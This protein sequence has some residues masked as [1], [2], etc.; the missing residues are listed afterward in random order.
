[1]KV[2]VNFGETRIVV[3]CKDGWMVRDLIDQ[4]TQRYKK[5][6]EQDG[7]FLV[8]TLHVE[9]VDG[10]ILD[11]DDML[12]DLVEDKDKL[13]AV[14]EKM[15][16]QQRAT[17]S[18]GGSVASGRSSPDHSEPELS[19]L[20]PYL[21]SEIEVTPSALKSTTPL[22]VRSSS[23]P[24]LAPPLDVISLDAEDISRPQSTG[25]G[26]AISV[27]GGAMDKPKV[28]VP[29]SR[30]VELSCLT[31]TV[32]ISGDLG[33]LGIKVISY[34]SSLSGRTLGLNIRAIERHSRSER[35]GI[36]EEDE[37]I[38]QINDTELI[39]KSFAQ[40]QEVFRLAM[41][42]TTIRLEV[43][44]VANKLRYEKSLIGQ[45]FNNTEPT[46]AVPKVKSPFLVH[47][48][49]SSNASTPSPEPPASRTPP[50][51]QTPPQKEEE[52]LSAR[53]TPVQTDHHRATPS[54][55]VSAS[56][57]LKDGSESP[58]P[59]K[60][61]TLA[62]VVNMI[63]KKPGKKMKIDLKKG[64]E[65]LGFTVVTRDSSLH[66]PGPIM[67]KSILPRGAAVKDGR[68]KSGDRILE[69]NGVDITGRTQEE[70]VA[71][72]RSTKLGETVSLVVG[73]QEGFLPRELKGEPSGPLLS[74]DG[75]EQL[76][77]E[78]P[79]NDSGSA[80]LGVSLKG[81][82]SR[83]TGEDLGI[84]IKSIIHGGA[85]HKD[86]RLRVNDQLIAV[87]SESLLGRSN[88]DAMETLRRS[89]STEGNLRG[90][91][92][93]VVLRSSER[94]AAQE[95]P[96]SSQT[97]T[98][99]DSPVHLRPNSNHTNSS[100]PPST[101]TIRTYEAAPA[102]YRPPGGP[103]ELPEEDYDEDDFPPPPSDLD[104]LETNHPHKHQQNRGELEPVSYKPT[105]QQ[106]PPRQK[107]PEY[108]ASKSSKSMD[109]VAD[110]SNMASIQGQRPEPP[111]SNGTVLGPR[112]GLQKSSS[113]ES[114]QTAMEE[115]GK[116]QVPF[117]RPRT[118][119]VRGR[120]C[121]LS[122]RYA[123]DKSYEGPS[124][125]EDDDSEEDSG[126]DTPASSSSRQDLD[127]EK[128]VKKKKTKKKKEKK[129][130]KKDESD[131]PEKKTKKKGFGLLR[132]GR[133][134]KSKAKE[135]GAL[136]EEE[137]DKSEPEMFLSKSER[138]SPALDRAIFPDV[139]DDDLDPNYARI[140]NFREPPSSG[141][142]PYPPGTPTHNYS[143]PAVPAPNREL[144]NEDALEGLYAKVNKQRTGPPKTDSNED[145]LQQIRNQLQQVRPAP[146]YDDLSARRRPEYDPSRIRGPDPRMAP[147]YSD[148]DR[149]YTSVPRR[150]PVED[151]TNQN[152]ANQ[153]DPVHY[154]NPIYETQ[155]N[156][157]PRFPRLP[158]PR[159][160]EAT[161]G[162]YP[163]SPAQQRGPV[164]Q[165]VPP[166]S[167]PGARA[168]PRYEALNQGNYRTASPDRYGPYG[169]EQYQDP[170]QKKPMIGAV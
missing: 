105:Y 23:D 103:Q 114:L 156:Y 61:P 12:T 155:E 95:N 129:S 35:E 70:L 26:H 128:K 151:Y 56:P 17:V 67:V 166:P 117:H 144:P 14:Y 16:L 110:E 18:P 45:L 101:E 121:N 89:M 154:P 107:V 7:E 73:R 96:E 46:P 77:F 62:T 33:P 51:S 138:N 34:C 122:F 127:D 159:P 54:P 53:H 142:S 164:R 41:S 169:D 82:K 40:S 69:V 31:R 78:V 148:S 136:S 108:P 106:Y 44:P 36:F 163:S 30:T 80:G 150:M 59:R 81:N 83:E 126:R 165:D 86:G 160:A 120:A 140:N 68:L 112:L 91:I 88:H 97:V 72:L 149:P 24:T 11:P 119:M 13:K 99:N 139:E 2:T 85:A 1:M 65:G 152:W 145:R 76:M 157:P 47:K 123:I 55:P 8:R 94:S 100:A 102:L 10:G 125:P 42:S 79:L 137:V 37:C 38:V 153:R 49:S 3:P 29:V 124:E 57:T 118:H 168:P 146:S 113:L 92:Q 104:L 4:A 21:G 52:L 60:T 22:S 20:Q 64:T 90:T 134:N 19:V 133:K 75:R 131:D 71:M 9:Y 50:T 74:E 115:V 109:L 32:E 6:A 28:D 143:Q 162:Y 161:G 39:D 167:N 87:N 15:E 43:L 66:G 170:R 130:K 158:V 147:R 48:L 58:A 63:N 141:H 111:S 5:I 84:F 93:L 116:D 132:F 98:R 135:L 25:V 27:K